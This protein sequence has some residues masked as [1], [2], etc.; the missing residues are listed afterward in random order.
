MTIQMAL[1][2]ATNDIILKDGGG[3]ERVD[4]GRYTVQAVRCRLQTFLGEWSLDTG[5]GWVNFEDFE[6]SPDLY[7]IEVRARE[8]ILSTLG[9]STIKS[10]N[11]ALSK[12]RKLVITFTATTIYGEISLEIP[13]GI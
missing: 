10:F 13:W 6:K 3:L 11:L 2:E 9:V 7:G 4:Q 12:D 8:I 1:D 5:V